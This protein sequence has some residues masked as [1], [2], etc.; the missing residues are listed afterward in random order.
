[1]PKYVAVS[2]RAPARVD[3]HGQ[4]MGSPAPGI[5]IRRDGPRDGPDICTLG[6]A[7]TVAGR[8][9]FLTAGHCDDS[10]TLQYAQVNADDSEPLPLGPAVQAAIGGAS[11]EYSDSA[12][13][14]TH[15]AAADDAVVGFPVAGE[16]TVEQTRSL[17]RGTPICV[18]GAVSG[19]RCGAFIGA[20]DGLIRFTRVTQPGDSGA[21]VFVVA[22]G[23]ATVIGV[24]KG[25]NDS[26]DSIA[27]FIAPALQR[28]GAQLVTAS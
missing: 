19:T 25:L 4:A 23:R 16:L 1:M 21:P 3:R 27:T 6:P 9:A 24:H 2:S 18:A 28:L 22:N 8:P 13:I 10:G 12:L 14:I 7:V 26:G 17:P 5:K 15:E 20:A 11:A